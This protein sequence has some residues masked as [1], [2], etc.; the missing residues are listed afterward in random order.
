MMHVHDA[1]CFLSLQT[2]V[3]NLAAFSLNLSKHPGQLFFPCQKRL[4]T[5]RADVNARVA[6]QL[7]TSA[8]RRLV[9]WFLLHLEQSGDPTS[10]CP[11]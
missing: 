1:R 8:R 4:A 7:L 2:R 11:D 6:Q 9:L 5:N 10:P 3:A